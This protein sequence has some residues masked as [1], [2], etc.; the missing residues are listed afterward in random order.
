MSC[1]SRHVPTGGSSVSGDR[2]GREA[3]FERF[4]RYG[5]ETGGTFMAS[6]ERWV[7]GPGRIGSLHTSHNG[8][9]SWE[10]V[11]APT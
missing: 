1:Q 10:P 7:S 3:V 11:R 5:G 9:K 6:L 2:E 4:G 8:R